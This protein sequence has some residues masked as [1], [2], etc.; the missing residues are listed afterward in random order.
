MFYIKD[1]KIHKNLKIKIKSIG[2]YWDKFNFITQN[3]IIMINL[4]FNSHTCYFVL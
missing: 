4:P 3:E 1:T 2:R